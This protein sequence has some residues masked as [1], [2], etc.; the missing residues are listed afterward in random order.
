MSYLFEI[1]GTAVIPTPS[2]LLVSPFKEIWE[3]DKNVPKVLALKEL[4]YIEFMS[5]AQKSNPFSGYPEQ[6]RGE[7]IRSNLFKD[8]PEWKPDSYIE[9][10][11]RFVKK[12]QTEGSVTYSYY[13]AARS[14]VENM[15]EFFLTVDLSKTNNSGM[16]VYKPKDITS[17]L[18]DTE[19][20]VQNLDALQKRVEEEMFESTRVKSDKTISPFADPSSLNKM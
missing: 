4:A 3:R 13:M 20:V 2:L 12:V 14:S 18:I 17:A 7:V 10:G 11:I 9:E 16:P 8:Y 6:N 15:K 19:K 5:S 1:N